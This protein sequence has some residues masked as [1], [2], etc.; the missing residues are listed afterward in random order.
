[1]GWELKNS[2]AELFPFKYI[3]VKKCFKDCTGSSFIEN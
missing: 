2:D 3:R 1:M